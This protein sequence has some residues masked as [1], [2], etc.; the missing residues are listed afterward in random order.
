MI[1]PATIQ[2]DTARGARLFD[3]QARLHHGARRPGSGPLIVT[4][5]S[6]PAR[7]GSAGRPW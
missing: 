6:D 4:G 5:G 7:I 3:N 1:E 2:A